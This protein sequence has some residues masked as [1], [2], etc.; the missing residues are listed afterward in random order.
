MKRKKKDDAIKKINQIDKRLNRTDKSLN[1][2]GEILKNMIESLGK[3]QKD[4]AEALEVSESY[5]SSIVNLRY[6]FFSDDMLEKIKE[7]LNLSEE[8][9][10]NL[11][12]AAAIERHPLTSPRKK[13]V[14]GIVGELPGILFNAY[15]T[16][17]YFQLPAEYQ[18]TSWA[19]IVNGNHLIQEGIGDHAKLVTFPPSPKFTKLTVLKNGDLAIIRFGQVGEKKKIFA[20]GKCFGVVGTTP[21]PDEKIKILS[22]RPQ[23]LEFRCDKRNPSDL[24]QAIL[25]NRDKAP[26][27]DKYDPD[28][29]VSL[30]LNDYPLGKIVLAMKVFQE[31]E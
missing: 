20:A 17:E 5:I 16:K 29:T 26:A 2:A 15:K 11:K 25:D 30:E 1:R 8:E 24:V 6:R 23:Y 21:I 3:T 28:L 19:M 27:S 4:L 13:L 18:G 14:C 22:I 31:P 7:E 10:N 9:F 12:S